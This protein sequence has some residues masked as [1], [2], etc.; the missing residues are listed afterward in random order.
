VEEKREAQY[1]RLLDFKTKTDN[2]SAAQLSLAGWRN[3]SSWTYLLSWSAVL[4]AVF[5]I[6]IFALLTE[7]RFAK[8]QAGPRKRLLCLKD[9]C[10]SRFFSVRLS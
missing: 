6:A 4:R 2:R 8:R 3:H 9:S 1:C 5:Q 7:I 10:S